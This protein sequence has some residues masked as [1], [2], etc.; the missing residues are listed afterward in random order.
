MEDD[1]IL[2]ASTI[3]VFIMTARTTAI[4]IDL[5]LSHT[6]SKKSFAINSS[7]VQIRFWNFGI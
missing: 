5:T 3:D 2:Y 6:E 7:Y 4:N 1:G